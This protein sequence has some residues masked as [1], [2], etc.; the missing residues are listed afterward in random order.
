[1]F[2]KGYNRTVVSTVVQNINYKKNVYKRKHDV[3]LVMLVIF[4]QLVLILMKRKNVKSV[5]HLY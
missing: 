1:M 2:Y 4:S 5:S 3:I